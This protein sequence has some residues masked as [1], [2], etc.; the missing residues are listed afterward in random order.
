VGLIASTGIW[1]WSIIDAV[2]V[3]K[4][5][6]MAYRKRNKLGLHHF[7]PVLIQNLNNGQLTG[8][9]CFKIRLN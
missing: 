8:G 6:N 5:N 1:V 7:S 4:I 2:R 9:M 3:A